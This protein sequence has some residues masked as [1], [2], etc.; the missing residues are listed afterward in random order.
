[1]PIENNPLSQRRRG[2]CL[3][4]FGSLLW[5]VSGVNTQYLFHE[6]QFSPEW[7]V[8][9][10]LLFSGVILLAYEYLKNKQN[11]FTI[12]KS[13]D[14]FKALLLFS[15]VGMLSIQYT[16]F[17]AIAYGNAATATILQNLSPIFVACYFMFQYKKLPSFIET[18]AIALAIFGTFLLVTKGNIHSLAMSVPA[19]TWGTISGIAAAFYV[20]FPRKLLQKWNSTLV[21]GWAMLFAGTIMSFFYSPFHFVGIWSFTALL[22]VVFVIFFCTVVAFYCYID[23]IN[24]ISPTE[25][26]TLA[27]VEPLSA[28]ILSIVILNIPFGLTDC[29]GAL[30]IMMTVF[31]LAR[32]KS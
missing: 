28:V 31:I 14:D 18:S 5:G 9:M 1:M 2:V 16:Y 15:V 10:R 6:L 7:L 13:S 17:L 25:T 20:I 19:F 4:V 11:I 8:V 22:N 27:S 32:V 21:I 23:S 26:S 30:C 29:I 3:V 12:L 24:Y